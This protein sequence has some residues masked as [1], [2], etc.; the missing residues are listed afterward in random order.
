MAID[1]SLQVHIHVVRYDLRHHDPIHH[2]VA[3]LLLTPAL[4]S[5]AM[6]C[7]LD[8]TPGSF[9][10]VKCLQ[11]E[12][13]TSAPDVLGHVDV[14]SSPSLGLGTLVELLEAIPIV[15][16]GEPGW[17]EYNCRVWAELAV[18]LLQDDY[19]DADG[20]PRDARGAYQGPSWA[21]IEA[22]LDEQEFARRGVSEEAVRT[23]RWQ[24]RSRS[25]SLKLEY[26]RVER[27]HLRQDRAARQI[28]ALP[29]YRLDT[30]GVN[31]PNASSRMP[32]SQ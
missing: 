5:S 15:E 32:D 1:T 27:L 8:G 16:L 31:L 20:Y 7:E 22:D 25:P 21:A 29:D 23:H 24:L 11:P 30:Y 18:R 12:P 6:I 14:G 28:A 9:T 3:L 10:F 26:G 13:I 19:L 4:S 2:H 17:D